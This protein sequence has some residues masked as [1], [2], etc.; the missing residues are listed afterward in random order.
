MERRTERTLRALAIVI[1]IAAVLDPAITSPRST[2][3][4]IA[5]VD[6]H[7]ASEVAASDHALTNHATFEETRRRL[8]R[9]FT[10]V[11]A[12]F[13][14]A[15]G[16]VVV[17]DRLPTFAGEL[18]APL[19]AV[20]PDTTG[21]SVRIVDVRAPRRLA[22][23]GRASVRVRVHVRGGAGLTLSVTMRDGALLVDRV[24][25]ALPSRDVYVEVPLSYA[26]MATGVATLSVGATVGSSAA[27]SSAVIDVHDTPWSVLAYDAR[28]S[29]MSTFV[30]RA[31]ERDSRFA[32]SSRVVTSRN[33]TGRIST[34]A[35]Q[36]PPSFASPSSVD[37][38]DA[39]VVGAPEALSASDVRGIE[40][41]LRER[42][43]SVL[44]LIDHASA[45]AYTRLTGD[46]LR[47]SGSATPRMV[48]SVDGQDVVD[49]VGLRVSEFLSPMRVSPDVRTLAQLR[50]GAA[51]SAAGR[52]VVWSI[53]VGAGQVIISGALD[54][55]RYRDQAISGF[56]RFWQNVL[57]AAAGE[58]PPPLLVETANRRVLPN[59]RVELFVTVRDAVLSSRAIV[60]ATV[61]ADIRGGA[62]SAPVP[63]RLW[64]NGAA[65]QFR[66]V[67][68]V[69]GDTGSYTLWAG[70]DGQSASTPIVVSRA[71][72]GAASGDR[73]LIAAWAE[74]RGG[75]AVSST[76]LEDLPSFLQSGVRPL[77][78]SVVWHPMRSA[79]WIIPFALLLGAEWWLR[80]RGGRA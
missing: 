32:V 4:V 16:T 68:R 6:A 24:D 34:D 35:G 72:V 37:R 2:R 40:R 9:D 73:E 80:R 50:R 52:T 51:D 23:H 65:G 1:A 60:R 19:F 78:R 3:P 59:E 64:P 20:L 56:D 15:A 25:R 76:Q 61:A 77:A 21:T 13:A 46:V 29:W 55:W 54:A 66:G 5:V 31:I 43:G 39:I 14:N 69:P 48:E 58:S 67:V 57:A 12:P 71:A 33:V 79:W 70:G 36:P 11:P 45:G 53:P 28:P 18:A 47:H 10:V 49:S 17:G 42:G 8:D 38:F 22:L 27:A 62:L 30:R 26:P 75:H 7:A 44:L 63:V 41:Y 74:T